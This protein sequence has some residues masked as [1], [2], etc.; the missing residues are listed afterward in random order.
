MKKLDTNK[1]NIASDGKIEEIQRFD[2]TAVTLKTLQEL[3]KEI[4]RRYIFKG[5]ILWGIS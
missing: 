1:V 3:F 5:G 4:E 2:I